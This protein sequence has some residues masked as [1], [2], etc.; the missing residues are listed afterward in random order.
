MAD[1]IDIDAIEAAGL[2]DGL[3]GLARAERAE[4]IE[5]LLAEGFTLEHIGSEFAPML[6]PAGRVVGDD[7]VYV[8]SRQIC[9]D[10][11]IDLELLEAMQRALGLPR[12]DDPTAKV[13]LRV[14]AEAAARAKVFVDVG[15]TR[16]QLIAVARVLGH[17][18]AQA[19]EVMRQVVLET[20][21]EPGAT[22]L[23][24]AKAYGE[25]VQRASPLLGPLA[26]G[27]L[28]LQLRHGLETEAVRLEGSPVIRRPSP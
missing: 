5:W 7:G 19:A 8:S 24:I 28:R 12:V 2:L 1:D 6:M 18:M 14:D 27:V 13:Y 16:E 9:E 25:L 23:Q 21:I 22:E 10:T 4:L 17:G 15:F 11:G 20:V 26:E 3:E